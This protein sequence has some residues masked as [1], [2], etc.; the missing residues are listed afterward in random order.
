MTDRGRLQST[1][2]EFFGRDEELDRVIGLLLRP[3]R[4]ITLLGPGGVG[5]TRLA[6]ETAHKY[7]KA[8]GATAY[9]VPL[10]RLPAGS[11]LERV[12]EE[13]S[14]TVAE[15][16]FSSHSAFDALAR[17]LAAADTA[18]RAPLLVLDNCEH[19]LDGVGMLVHGLLDSVPN[20]VVMATS[21]APIGFVDEHRVVVP[22]LSDSEAIAL[23]R[24]RSALT[25]H[26]VTEESDGTVGEICR[27][28]DNYPLHVQLAA[29]RLVRRPLA[30]ILAELSGDAGDARLKWTDGKV[31]GVDPRHHGVEEAIGWSY[32]LCTPQEQL[33]FARLAVFAPGS[34]FLLNDVNQ[35]GVDLAA[36]TAVC[37]DDP[38]DPE[39]AATLSAADIPDLLYS[40]ADQSLVAVHEVGD[41]VRFSLVESLRV[42]A[43]QR[44][45][46]SSESTRLTRRHLYYYR[47]QV[48]HWAAQW[49]T[50]GDQHALDWAM[51]SWHDIRAAVERGT[52]VPGDETAG[53]EIC[54]SLLSMRM[55]FVRGSMRETRLLCE[56]ALTAT[57]QV[58]AEAKV[59]RVATMAATAMIAICQGDLGDTARLLDECVA[60]HLGDPELSRVWRESADTDIGLLPP[61]EIAWGHE[62]F[63]QRDDRA[64]TVLLRAAGKCAQLGDTGAAAFCELAAALAAGMLRPHHEAAAIAERFLDGVPAASPAWLAS[65]AELVRAI[66]LTKGGKPAAAI[67]L[68]RKAL[69]GL[70]H[71]REQSAVLWAV[72]ACTWSQAQLIRDL[73]AS[74]R[75]DRRRL[76]ALATE[77]AQLLGAAAT[78]C[79]WT[80]FDISPLGPF[81]D[82]TVRAMDT[83]RAVLGEQRYAAAAA[84]G[85]RLRPELDEV[86]LFAMGKLGVAQPAPTTETGG[87]W[88]ELTK[89]EKEV[90]MLA[91]AGWTNS[92]I[93]TRRG[94]SRKT[95]DAQ[96]AAVLHKL[97]IPSREHILS[98][99]PADQ[100]DQVRVRAQP[101]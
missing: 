35:E 100:V 69:A 34:H 19:V 24:N 60:L 97:Q 9:W 68:Q 79:T 101:R 45:A 64:V 46:E 94:T 3:A 2:A 75:A 93:A 32:E 36:V 51:T 49:A 7:V 66:V 26:P 73:R 17:A 28:M 84:H 63:V 71:A 12:A 56:W 72:H 43:A 16:D 65:W 4:Q 77:T 40:L 52:A 25:G 22:P 99:V 13:A 67:A 23:F 78:L 89:A 54:A 70:L 74:G 96:I 42:F 55:A 37:T 6:E 85:A 61:I 92:T 80:G 83:A 20:L 27:R 90:A 76:V 33:L 98:R 18:R 21:R 10:A 15:N 57:K 1:H 31:F 62:L 87:I 44:L 59:L 88:D 30:M 50:T 86:A 8:T 82:E 38:T 5:K 14:H 11:D 39:S 58:P 41:T 48:S 81:F 29:A 95:V 47:D 91:A 53:L